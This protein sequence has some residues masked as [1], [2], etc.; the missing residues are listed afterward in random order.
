MRGRIEGERMNTLLDVPKRKLYC[1]ISPFL[2]FLGSVSAPLS[3]SA[4]RPLSDSFVAISDAYSFYMIF[5][6]S[7]WRDMRETYI[8]RSHRDDEDLPGRKPEGP[9]KKPR[10]N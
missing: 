2:I 5:C 6:N 7:G 10:V 4:K 9:D 3:T 1:A 8:R